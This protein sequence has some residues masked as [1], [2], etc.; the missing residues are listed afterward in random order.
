MPAVYLAAIPLALVQIALA[1]RMPEHALRDHTA[2]M[3]A[4][5]AAAGERAVLPAEG[6]LV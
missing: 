1:W 4:P 6:G 3:R 2:A 5:A